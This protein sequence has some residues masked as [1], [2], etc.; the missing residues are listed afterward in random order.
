MNTNCLFC[1]C[2]DSFSCCH[3]RLSMDTPVL[4][5]PN[6][7]VISKFDVLTVLLKYHSE[8]LLNI[9]L[10]LNLGDLEMK[11]KIEP[12]EVGVFSLFSA[13]SQY[14]LCLGIIQR[15]KTKTNRNIENKPFHLLIKIKNLSF[16]F[17]KTVKN[18]RI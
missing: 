17:I 12:S 3:Y 14:N 2:Y 15:I 9:S 6:K 11:V 18:C 7:T 1:F 4:Y 5:Q 10:T 13:Q 16:F 8:F